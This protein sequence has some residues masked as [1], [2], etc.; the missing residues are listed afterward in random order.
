MLRIG[1]IAGIFVCALF[2]GLAARSLLEGTGERHQADIA[3]LLASFLSFAA[4]GFFELTRVLRHERRRREQRFKGSR[5]VEEEA[6]EFVPGST[7]IYAMPETLEEWRGGRRPRSSG[8]HRRRRGTKMKSAWMSA[9]RLFCVVVP[10]AYVGQLIVRLPWDGARE[11]SE[12]VAPFV[13]LALFLLSVAVGVGVFSLRFW[14]LVLGYL[15]VLCNL[16]LFP[17]GTALGLLLLLCLAGSSPIFFAVA[18]DRRH[19]T[20]R[21]R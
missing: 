9:L 19:G 8:S 3:I 15:L 13:F 6:A 1:R 16:F 4:L 20:R 21:G 11:S 5:S 18:R 12:W 17:Y 14:G 7:D 10:L 2:V